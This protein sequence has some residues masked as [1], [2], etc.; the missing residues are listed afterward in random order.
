MF[1]GVLLREKAG[2][3]C[4][5]RST[6]FAFMGNVHRRLMK[7]GVSGELLISDDF[8]KNLR[9]AIIGNIDGVSVTD[10]LIA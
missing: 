1:F 5:S 4:K 3:G 7:D 2:K 6:V 10:K 9:E 8:S